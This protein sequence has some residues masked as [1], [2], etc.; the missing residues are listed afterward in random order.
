MTPNSLSPQQVADTINR[1][2]PNFK[3]FWED[4]NNFDYISTFIP[5]PDPAITLFQIE[6]LKVYYALHN[7]RYMRSPIKNSIDKILITIPYTGFTN[8]SWNTRKHITNKS[9]EY[10]NLILP[11]VTDLK[12]YLNPYLRKKLGFTATKTKDIKSIKDDAFSIELFKSS[13]G[14]RK[15]PSTE[16]IEYFNQ[17]R[18]FTPVNRD[19]YMDIIIQHCTFPSQQFQRAIADSSIY[20]VS[21]NSKQA[22]SK[23]ISLDRSHVRHNRNPMHPVT[24]ALLD[25]RD[26]D[27]TPF[28]CGVPRKPTPTEPEV[29]ALVSI[30]FI[31][32]ASNADQKDYIIKYIHDHLSHPDYGTLYTDALRNFEA[33]SNSV[34]STIKDLP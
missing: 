26:S 13:L 23:Y 5:H 34:L 19:A 2:K 6:L 25:E 4:V 14:K 15:I 31:V 32:A 27:Y 16:A 30:L 17:F 1:I 29:S 24:S 28:T 12:Q 21:F 22:N 11:Y 10:S 20:G 18:N 7:Q 3:Q 9:G 33:Y 8:F